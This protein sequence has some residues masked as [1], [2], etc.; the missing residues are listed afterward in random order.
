MILRRSFLLSLLIGFSIAVSCATTDSADDAGAKDR[1][2]DVSVEETGNDP[3]KRDMQGKGCIGGNCTQ[4]TGT[5]IYD[6][7]DRY[8]GPFEKGMR[9][10][11]GVMEYANGDRYEGSYNS[12]LR[13]GNG[14]YIF[15]SKDVYAG[16]FKDGLRE[17][18]GAYTFAAT[19]EV[20]EG[21]FSNDAKNGRGYIKRGS[22][23]YLCTIDAGTMFCDTKPTK[24]PTKIMIDK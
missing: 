10:G 21:N 17:G 18:K 14:T 7:G 16:Q 6:T 22:D 2:G 12:D 3:K 23:F 15:K 5:Y 9:E 13:Q 4:G 20:F 24:D 8:T 11:T 19:G 1:S